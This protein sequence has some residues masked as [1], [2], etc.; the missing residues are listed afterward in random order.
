MINDELRYKILRAM[1]QNPNQTQRE[2]AKALGISLGKVNFCIKAL[3]EVGLIKAEN[4]KNNKNKLGYAYILTPKGLEEKKSVTARF[5]RGKLHE[6][7][8][9]EREI[10]EI[11]NQHDNTGCSRIV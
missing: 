3:L 2:M 9:I 6:Y 5:L 10:R 4:F 8:V 7:A 1:E 11:M